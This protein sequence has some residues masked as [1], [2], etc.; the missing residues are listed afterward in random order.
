MNA[1]FKLSERKKIINQ[2]KLDLE[3][4][5]NNKIIHA[6]VYGSTLCEDFSLNSDFDILIILKEGDFQELIKLKELKKKYLEKGI[7]IDFNVQLENEAPQKRKKLFWHNNRAYYF[8]KEIQI[9]GL[10]LIGSSPFEDKTITQEEI[11]SEVVKV[12]NSLLYQARKLLINTD[13][14][15]EE[16]IRMM[17]FCIYGVLYALA[18]KNIYP[19]TKKEALE[20]FSDYFTLDIDPSYFLEKKINFE[21]ISFADLKQAYHFLSRLDQELFNQYQRGVL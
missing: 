16:R 12:V 7:K 1:L 17:K 3:N 10:S 21:N 6:L 18:A 11:K 20:I 2:I 19:K 9:Y 15:L 5:F 8:Q 13:I 14:S 4:K